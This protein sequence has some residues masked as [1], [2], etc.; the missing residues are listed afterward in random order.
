MKSD[1][2][3]LF[4]EVFPAFFAVAALPAGL[5]WP[6]RMELAGFIMA[7]NLVAENPGKDEVSMALAPHLGIG[8][9]DGTAG[10]C[11]DNVTV[12]FFRSRTGFRIFELTTLGQ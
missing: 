2:A 3:H 12:F 9:A 4:A 7:G 8:S 6:D 11:Q 5:S 1:D 10:H